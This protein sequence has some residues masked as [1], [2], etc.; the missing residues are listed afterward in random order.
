MTVSVR[1]TVHLSSGVYDALATEYRKEQS[2]GMTLDF[3][4]Y[5]DSLAA[6]LIEGDDLYSAACDR[7]Y[8]K[9]YRDSLGRVIE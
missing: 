8:G 5:L 6:G 2:A 3:S 9:V 7:T 1:V 4:A